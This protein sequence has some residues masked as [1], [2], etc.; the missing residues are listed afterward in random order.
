MDIIST[1]KGLS[2]LEK[3][4][5]LLPATSQNKAFRPAL[6]E[7][8]NVVRDAVVE[9]IK[10]SVGDESTGFLSKNIRTYQLRK[11]RGMLRAGVRAKR[12]AVYT[13]KNDKEGPVRAGLVLGVREY[14][15][16][17][18]APRP[19]MREA[20][21]EKAQKVLD[22]VTKSIRDRMPKAIEDAKK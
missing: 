5:R 7:G 1:I 3:A 14:G 10:S 21:R 17:G 9:N 20:S 4:F 8:A 15:K 2:E 19:A 6:R 16:D 12:G 11:Y 18:Q 13:S 22:V